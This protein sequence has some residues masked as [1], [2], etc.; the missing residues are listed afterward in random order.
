MRIIFFSLFCF[1]AFQTS[2]QLEP[3]KWSFD[4]EKVNETEYNII[5]TASI[6][7]GWS[8]YSQFS[9]PN[10]GPIPTSFAFD[11]SSGLELIGKMREIGN[12]KESFDKLFG[13]KLVK[14]MGKAKFTQR[15]RIDQNATSVQGHLTYMTC[16]GKSCLP[17][18]N[19]DFNI[20]LRQ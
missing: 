18:E 15:V 4:A 13:M 14:F 3:V 20:S 10:N 2:A 16:D 8:V 1:L 11:P 17:P 6:D 5:F 7:R 19:I 12:K 9:D